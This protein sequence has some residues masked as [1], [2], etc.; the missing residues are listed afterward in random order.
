[1]TIPTKLSELST[2]IA[3]N[4]PA[5]TDAVTEGDDNIRTAFAL[6]RQVVTAGSDIA[7]ASS[8]SLPAGFHA[9]GRWPAGLQLIGRPLDEGTIFSLAAALEKAADFTEKPTRWWA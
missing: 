4:S 8:I 5:S 3:A 2:S 7:S 1:M 6:L 9:N